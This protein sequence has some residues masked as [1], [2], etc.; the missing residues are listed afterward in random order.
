MVIWRYN[1]PGNCNL[2][3]SLDVANTFG[4]ASATCVTFIRSVYAGCLVDAGNDTLTVYVSNWLVRS[5]ISFKV[6]KVI[7]SSLVCTPLCR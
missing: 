5:Y 4:Y 1:R 2:V 7:G 3:Y 6:N